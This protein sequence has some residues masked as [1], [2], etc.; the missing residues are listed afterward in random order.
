ME[1]S[2]TG[3]TQASM[4]GRREKMAPD[5]RFPMPEL[6]KNRGPHPVPDITEMLDQLGQSK[7]LRVSIW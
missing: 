5:S 4:R 1:Q 3:G 2:D 6:E 7:F